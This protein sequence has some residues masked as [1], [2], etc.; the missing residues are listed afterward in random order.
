MSRFDRL[1]DV[2]QLQ[3]A[4][5]HGWG[6]GPAYENEIKTTKA[7]VSGVITFHRART[8]AQDGQRAV[9]GRCRPARPN[10]P[11]GPARPRGGGGAR[12]SSKQ[13]LNDNGRA[14]STA[15]RVP[16][17][18]TPPRHT[19]SG[20][21][22]L[23]C[24]RRAGAQAGFGF[25]IINVMSVVNLE[26]RAEA[27]RAPQLT[28][29][30]AREH[31]RAP[32][33]TREHPRFP[34]MAQPSSLVDAAASLSHPA[35]ASSSQQQPAPGTPKRDKY[36]RSRWCLPPHPVLVVIRGKTAPSDVC[37]WASTLVPPSRA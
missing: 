1:A 34:Y 33:S 13:N 16:A 12:S 19:V 7:C 14:P 10:P 30:V 32:E 27:P 35:A 21:D 28:V 2:F 9:L 20:G 29:Q 8:G 23:S 37:R 6:G 18:P 26:L 31:P 22:R 24:L 3:K 5:T 4:R 11:P 15:A 25:A 17:A 36:L